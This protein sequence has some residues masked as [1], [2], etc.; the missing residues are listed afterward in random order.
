LAAA[1]L[2]AA[3]LELR[4]VYLVLVGGAVA[5]A[6]MHVVLVLL[7]RWPTARTP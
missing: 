6:S 4:A 2:L 1:L 5:L 7:G 3:R